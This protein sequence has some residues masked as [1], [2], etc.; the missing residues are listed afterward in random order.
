MQTW[1]IWTLSVSATVLLVII[2]AFIVRAIVK[3][4]K[5][6]SIEQGRQVGESP[7]TTARHWLSTNGYFNQ[8]ASN[9]GGRYQKDPIKAIT[10]D[11]NMARRHLQAEE[12][13]REMTPAQLAV[14]RRMVDEVERNMK[15]NV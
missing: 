9:F 6:G 14:T 2:V 7:E 5:S 3:R 8:D 12:D 13:R 1:L 4:R 15:R 10:D 11:A